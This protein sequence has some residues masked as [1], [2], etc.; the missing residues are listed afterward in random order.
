[1]ARKKKNK[2]LINSILSIIII[3]IIAI[4]SQNQKIQSYLANTNNINNINIDLSSKTKNQIE[5]TIQEIKASF[6]VNL[7]KSPIFI[8]DEDIKEIIALSLTLLNEIAI[9]ISF[10]VILFVSIYMIYNFTI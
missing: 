3:I 9:N 8:P 5:S 7:Y 4:I 10:K 2:K 1:M 6:I